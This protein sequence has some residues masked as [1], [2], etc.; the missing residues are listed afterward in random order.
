M[1][2]TL[3]ALLLATGIQH[4]LYIFPQPPR[5]DEPIR[6]PP[7]AP[8][9]IAGKAPQYPEA[10]RRARV[11]GIV[12]VELLIEKDG[13]VSAVH[14]VKPLPFGLDRAVVDAAR[15]WRFK[16][17]LLHGRPV[18]VIWQQAVAMNLPS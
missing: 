1:M 5:Y 10:A 12:I 9:R 11:S 15:T 16:P 4:P 3:A 17:M 6:N 13:R 18:R 14:L 7:H 8:V 2:L